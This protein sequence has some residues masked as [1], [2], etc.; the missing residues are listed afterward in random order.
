MLL[1]PARSADPPISSGISVVNNVRIS[2]EDFLVAVGFASLT[3]A[4]FAFVKI[5]LSSFELS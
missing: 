4:I 2:S 1:D 3:A 5:L